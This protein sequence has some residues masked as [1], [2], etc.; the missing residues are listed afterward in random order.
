MACFSAN[1][2]LRDRSFMRE[3]LTLAIEEMRLRPRDRA[4]FLPVKLTACDL[5]PLDLGGGEMLDDVHHISLYQDW[6][7]GMKALLAALKP[8]DLGPVE[9]APRGQPLK[10]MT[11]P[12]HELTPPSGDAPPKS[13]EHTGKYKALWLHLSD[14]TA[15]ILRVTFDELERIIGF[16]LPSSSRRYLQ[17]WRSYKASAI[18]RAI[19]DAGWRTAHVDIRDESVVLRRTIPAD[20]K[21]SPF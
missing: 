5:P 7:V 4:W 16:P 20:R 21:R 10:P 9:E 11:R 2:E 15:Q 6:D 17:Y 14:E 18:A 8:E 3:E 19:Q 13:Q 12:G 1:S